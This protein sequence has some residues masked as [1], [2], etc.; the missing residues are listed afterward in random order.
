MIS[1]SVDFSEAEPFLRLAV[2]GLL[3]Q[4]CDNMTPESHF[5]WSHQGP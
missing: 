3:Q 5:E 4:L 2:N 1:T